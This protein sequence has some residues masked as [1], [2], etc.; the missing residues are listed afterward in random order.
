MRLR[1]LG[2]FSS[3]GSAPSENGRVEGEAEVAVPFGGARRGMRVLLQAAAGVNGAAAF[4]ILEA[5][6]LRLMGGVLEQQCIPDG[7]IPGMEVG[8]YVRSEA[9]V[10]QSCPC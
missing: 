9:A 2:G 5:R 6:R 7:E 1:V 8:A 4:H 10:D 3:D